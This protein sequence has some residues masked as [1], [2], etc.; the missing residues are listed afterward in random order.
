MK[1]STL[2]LLMG[3]LALFAVP[4]WSQNRTDEGFRYDYRNAPPA[5]FRGL[6]HDRYRVERCNAGGSARSVRQV[7]EQPLGQR[8]DRRGPHARHGCATDRFHL[9]RLRS[10]H[11]RAGCDVGS[12]AADRFASDAYR[13]RH[14]R[15]G[16]VRNNRC[17]DPAAPWRRNVS[18]SS[19]EASASPVSGAVVP[20]TCG[21]HHQSGVTE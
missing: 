8:H 5:P 10:R 20:G 1:R 12:A 11:H 15:D 3:L 7:A 6:R 21:L 14:R 17:V 13:R 18:D 16:L 9:S 2:L 4:A 19:R